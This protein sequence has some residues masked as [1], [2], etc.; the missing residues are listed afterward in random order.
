M[1]MTHIYKDHAI[2]VC[3]DHHHTSFI[4]KVVVGDDEYRYIDSVLSRAIGS[5]KRKIDEVMECEI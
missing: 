4:V 3:P 1:K 2:D 5:A